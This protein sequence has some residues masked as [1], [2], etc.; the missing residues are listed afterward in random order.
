MTFATGLK[1]K[2]KDGTTRR[3]YLQITNNAGEILGYKMITIGMPLIQKN[4]KWQACLGQCEETKRPTGFR[5]GIREL[6]LTANYVEPNRAL[7]LKNYNL[8]W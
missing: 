7:V 5:G 6:I 1:N 2:A 3:S 4:W 8:G